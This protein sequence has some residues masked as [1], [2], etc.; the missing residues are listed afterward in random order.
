MGMGPRKILK[1]EIGNM[2]KANPTLENNLETFRGIKASLSD[3]IDESQL[4]GKGWSSAK[5]TAHVF[6]VL[7]DGFEMVTEKLL[8][9]NNKVNKTQDILLNDQIDEQALMLRIEQN[10]A[11]MTEL[12]YAN[13]MWNSANPGKTN[14]NSYNNLQHSIVNENAELQKDLDSLNEFDLSTKYLYDD[15]ERDIQ[16]LMT[17]LSKV[18]DSSKLYDSKTGKFNTKGIDTRFLEVKI[19]AYKA[20]NDEKITITDIEMG[21]VPGVNKESIKELKRIAKAT[22]LS[23]LDV[24]A[25]YAKAQK[26]G[27]LKAGEGI[28]SIWDFIA[29]EFS[30]VDFNKKTDWNTF[31]NRTANGAGVYFKK[32]NNNHFT[33]VIDAAQ[34]T[35]LITNGMVVGYGT[36]GPNIDTSPVVNPWDHID[37]SLTN[38]GQGLDGALDKM[39]E[40]KNSIP[41]YSP[42]GN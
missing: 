30:K 6:K 31:A 37:E 2:T 25:L 10:K 13:S 9:A 28:H 35:E 15:V 34:V 36:V 23:I 42:Y 22:G 41:P 24:I 17:L 7:N 11:T 3:F 12:A 16:S 20:R 19:S 40:N 21:R 1:S 4:T 33:Y 32:D 29:G 39:N 27:V 14:Q 5:E 38:L 8:E 18:S 26:E